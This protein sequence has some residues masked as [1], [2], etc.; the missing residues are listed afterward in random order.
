[1]ARAPTAG[2]PSRA[3]WRCSTT[4]RRTELNDRFRRSWQSSISPLGSAGKFAVECY[5]DFH[6]NK[7]TRRF[8]AN[9]YLTSSRR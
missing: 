7:F 5:L 2:S 9:S 6:G 4:A 3:G 1:M 8:D